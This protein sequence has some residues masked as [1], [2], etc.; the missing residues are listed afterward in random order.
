MLNNAHKSP[1]AGL[2]MEASRG[3]AVTSILVDLAH[4]TVSA[5]HRA[6]ERRKCRNLIRA[7]RREMEKL[8]AMTLRDI[9]WPARYEQQN[10]CARDQI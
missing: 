5:F 3:T 6:N 1:I 8:D 9:G 2:V 4:R 7:T 10:P